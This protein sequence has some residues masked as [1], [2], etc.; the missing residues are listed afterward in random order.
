MWLPTNV[1]FSKSYN[2]LNYT[3]SLNI[4]AGSGT[5]DRSFFKAVAANKYNTG[6]RMGN[7]TSFGSVTKIGGRY[8]KKTMAISSR[9]KNTDRL[10]IFLNEIRIGSLPEMFPRIYAW[11]VTR[12]LNGEIQRAEYI[13][14]DFTIV[15]PGQK[16]FIMKKYAE[17]L[18]ACPM[19]GHPIYSKIKEAVL[20]FWRITKGYHGDLHMENMAVVVKNK[21]P[22][23]VI[24]FDYGSHKKFKANT[25]NTTCFEDFLK[26]ID[27]EFGNRY[28][29]PTLNNRGYYPTFTKIRVAYPRRGQAIRPNTNMLR[30]MTLSG[31]FLPSNT[32]S[33][34]L[35]R[36]AMK[37]SNQTLMSIMH[38]A[39]KNLSKRLT[40]NQLRTERNH[41]RLFTTKN[42]LERARVNA[43]VRLGNALLNFYVKAYPT[44]KR[45]EIRRAIVHSYKNYNYNEYKRKKQLIFPNQ[46]KATTNAMINNVRK[47]TPAKNANKNT[48]IAHFKKVHPTF[49]NNKIQS[50]VNAFYN[51]NV[52]SPEA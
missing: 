52:Q 31:K 20:K 28:K 30:A 32:P 50:L 47:L 42:I 4:I 15:P 10:K 24:I 21:E 23:K 34:R 9:G 48:V 46:N 16:V 40:S 13:M 22:V 39:N 44:R 41:Q 19:Q 49:S 6:Q 1:K 27:K 7:A 2:R 18:G 5:R 11:R 37:A 33:K 26:I 38:S 29:K 25:G 36:R 8:V 12:D 17:S 43:G 35:E 14:D 51:T 3:N 45:S